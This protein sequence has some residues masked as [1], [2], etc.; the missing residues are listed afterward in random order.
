MSPA[1]KKSAAPKA[2]AKKT[3]AWPETVAAV[4]AKKA[5]PVVRPVAAPAR[6]IV[7]EPKPAFTP[8][9]K[10]AAAPVVPAA[11][12]KPAPVA[13]PVPAPAPKP[14][15]PGVTPEQRK[16]MIEQEAYFKAEK[17]KFKG[18]PH[19]FWVAAEKEIDARLAGKK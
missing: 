11:A 16:R 7:A 1:K 4:P 9:S 6:N 3:P 14:A 19:D 15:V 5:E 13:A 8:V 18:N 17:A 10:P 2:A 12:P